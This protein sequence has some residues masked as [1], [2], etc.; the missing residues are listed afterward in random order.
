MRAIDLF[1]GLGGF[2]EGARLA[3]VPVV[4]AANHWQSAVDVHAVNHPEVEHR[5]QDLHQADWQ[6][7][8]AFDIGLASPA[9]QGHSR[10][11]GKD[12]PHHDATRS[13]AWAVVS[14]AEFHR[15]AC[16]VVENVPEFLAW[17]LFPA[18]RL[19][20]E[21]LGYALAPHVI[22]AADHGVPQNRV[23]VYIVC[24]RSRAPLTL[25]L[26]RREHV[27]AA[28]FIDWQAGA[29]SSVRRKCPR[30]RRRIAAGRA[31]HGDRFLAPY[32][33]SGSGLAGRT[34]ARPVGTISTRDRWAV[35]DGARM[36]CLTAEECRA[37]MGFRAD[38]RLPPSSK[39]A[40]H[41][42]GNAVCPPAVA[43]LLTAIQAQA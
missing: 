40:K 32:Y 7:V 19:A 21:T 23:R 9:C 30:T 17:P 39:L 15:P 1:A 34:L 10:A 22:D 38:Y 5:C 33:G 6:Q 29:W 28:S 12:R 36:R 37:A 41:L 42:L 18:W 20:M 27:P 3:G 26:P 4:W 43:D 16:F 11:R 8:P 2:T 14:C 13:T 35:I 25:A 31:A 24:T